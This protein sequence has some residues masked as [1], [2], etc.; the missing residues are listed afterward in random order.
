MHLLTLIRFSLESIKISSNIKLRL[1]SFINTPIGIIELL[2]K[3]ISFHQPTN[4][5]KIFFQNKQYIQYLL[6]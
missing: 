3:K 1:V 4:I 6:N 2:S 5:K